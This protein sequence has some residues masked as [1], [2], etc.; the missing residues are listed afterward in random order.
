MHEL[1][2]FF[3]RCCG[4]NADVEEHET[5]DVDGIVDAIERIQDESMLVS[6]ALR[7]LHAGRTSCQTSIGTYPLIARTKEA[8]AIRTNLNLFIPHLIK[9]L[10]LTPL[11]YETDKTTKHSAPILSLL[12]NWLHSMSS[13]PLRPIRHTSTHLALRVCSALCDIAAGVASELSLTQ[14]QKD[15]EAK[16]GAQGPA[17]K[18]RLAELEAKVKECKDKKKLL[19]NYMQETFDV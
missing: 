19:H 4:L 10:S 2:Q 7:P 3:I 13:S 15:A 17:G 18:K 6:R 5:L 16:K 11:F 9:T 14:R 1:I 12:F 8:K